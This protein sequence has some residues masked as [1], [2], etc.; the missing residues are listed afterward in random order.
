[1]EETFCYVCVAFSL[2]DLVLCSGNYLQVFL[3]CFNQLV[4]LFCCHFLWIE[5]F[6]CGLIKTY[7][8]NMQIDKLID[9]FYVVAI[10][11]RKFDLSNDAIVTAINRLLIAKLTCH[12]VDC[13]CL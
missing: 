13:C 7:H 2:C 4:Y 5:S 12:V 11:R 3:M 10:A 9:K 1:M 6:P 8:K